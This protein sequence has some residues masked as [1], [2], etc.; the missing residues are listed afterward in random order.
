MSIDSAPVRS[1]IYV[2]GQ[3]ERMV[4]KSLGLP[5]DAIIYDLEDAVPTAEKQAARDLLTRMLAEP[6]APGGPRRYVRVNHP[7]HGD[8]FEAD[9]ACATR[10]GI[11]GI[12]L[13]KVESADEVRSV[14][15]MLTVQ[16]KQADLEVGSIRIMLL[17]E[18]PLGMVNAYAIAAS[19]PRIAAVAFGAEDFSRELGLPLV[20]TA[21][22]KEMIT[23]RSTIAIAAS[24]AGVQ[25]IDVIWTALSD[26]VGLEAEAQ[27]ARRLG[28]TGKAAIHPDQL[29]PI[30]RAFSPTD[31]EV[32]Y[33][34]EVMEAYD[35]AV[36]EGTGAI[37]YK[38][39]FLEE[40]VIAR[41]RQVLAMAERLR[42]G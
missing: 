34:K 3:R 29:A 41:A 18:S 38:G 40:P 1:W 23:A 33:A 9:L 5:A 35:A 27:Q 2:P 8:V 17:I 19:S 7:S 20:K 36:A 31:E 4:E 10:L 11:E 25:S 13:P 32:A 15:D 37:N 28:F 39:N 24:A 30:N 42:K 12:G 6:P 21:E 16:E 26:L 22:A 14:D